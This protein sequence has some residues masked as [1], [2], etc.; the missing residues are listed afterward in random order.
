MSP[1]LTSIDPL[2]PTA[3]ILAAASW[4]TLHGFLLTSHWCSWQPLTAAWVSNLRLNDSLFIPSRG[5]T[6]DSVPT[7]AQ[8]RRVGDLMSYGAN[9]WPVGGWFLLLLLS[10]HPLLMDCLEMWFY[11]AYQMAVLQHDVISCTQ[12]RLQDNAC[13]CWLS[14]LPCLNPLGSHFCL[15]GLPSLTR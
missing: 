2:S 7:F 1:P 3:S 5:K 15:L 11:M 10:P 12:R 9:L 13:S 6:W 8:P 4:P 14:F